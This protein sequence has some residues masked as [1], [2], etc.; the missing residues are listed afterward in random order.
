MNCLDNSSNSNLNLI[1]KF[2]KN[3]KETVNLVPV[4]SIVGSPNVGKST[5]VNRILRTHKTVVQDMPGVTKDRTSHPMNWMGCN[6]TLQDT[7]GWDPYS[8]GVQQLVVNQTLIAMQNSDLVLFVVDSIVGIT[9]TDEA[10]AQI[11][12]ISNI[13]VLLI[14]NKVDAK[15]IELK[16]SEFW[17]LGL[18]KPYAISATHGYKIE[19]LLNLIIKK[20]PKIAKLSS[21]KDIYHKVAL[22]GK[23]N[24]GKSSLLNQL[25]GYERSVVHSLPGTTIDPVESLVKLGNKIWCFTDTAGLRRKVD[26]ASGYE[27]YASLRTRRIINEADIVIMLIDVSQSLTEQDSKVLSMIIEAGSALVIALNKNDLINSNQRCLLAKKIEHTL[28]QLNWVQKISISAITRQSI[29][30]LIPA[31]ETALQSW[32][33]RISTSKLNNFI[34]ETISKNPPSLFNGKQT[35]IFFITQVAIKPP[36]FILF[37]SGLLKSSYCR[38]LEK[39][40]RTNLNFKG[41][42]IKINLRLR[43]KRISNM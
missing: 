5:L 28:V 17:K 32:N 19:D 18:G 9:T 31:L 36:T 26:K 34:R 6:F 39:K 4:L 23:P 37:T 16:V 14:A 42:P 10:A 7:G 3:K 41:S 11:L 29:L 15:Y 1:E 8:K 13:P 33:K 22:I 24:V 12:K 2:T 40:I 43:E 30:K 38:F 20:L 21:A 25:V 35:K 27:F